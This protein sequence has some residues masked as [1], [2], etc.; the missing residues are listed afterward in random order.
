MS[1][2]RVCDC[3]HA[4]VASVDNDKLLRSKHSGVT[5]AV[6][7]GEGAVKTAGVTEHVSSVP[8]C[9]TIICQSHS[10]K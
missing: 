2:R 9:N 6:L 4:G 7:L 5:S 3:G 1:L 10:V 8:V